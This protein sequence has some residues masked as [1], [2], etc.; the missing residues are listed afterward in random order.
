MEHKKLPFDPV[1]AEWLPNFPPQKLPSTAEDHIALAPNVQHEERTLQGPDGNELI[2]SIF[3]RKGASEEQKHLGIYQVHGGGFFLGNRFLIA[4]WSIQMVEKFDAVCMSIEYRL[5]PGHQNPAQINDCYAGLEWMAEHAK[6]FGIDP[7]KILVTGES[8]GGGLSAGLALM[9]RD[10]NGPK[11]M[12]QIVSS[13]Q[14]D[15]RSE[16]FSAHQH[17]TGGTF[18]RAANVAAWDWYLGK[19]EATDAVSIYAAPNRATDLSGLPPAYIDCGAAEV[20]RDEAVE[21]AQK[22]WRHGVPC[23]LHIW[24]G[25]F[26]A[27]DLYCPEAPVT[28]TAN[29]SKLLWL[30]RLIKSKE[31][32]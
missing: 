7:S 23:E 16:S 10:R 14:L 22:L 5:A 30:E 11:I 24:D 18:D 31:S 15:D 17:G 2:M 27:F 4:A 21:Y 26:H 3:R 13:P 32:K 12:G 8:A 25:A 19:R 6:E 29:E 9:A 20:F 1:L 28:V